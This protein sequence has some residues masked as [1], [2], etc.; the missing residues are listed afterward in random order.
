MV[1]IIKIVRSLGDSGLLIDG[2]TEKVKHEI[3]KQKDGFCGAMMRLRAASLTAP[4]A[5]SWIEPV[6]SSFIKGIS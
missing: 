4:V 6:A 5:S 2:V 1:D 3:K